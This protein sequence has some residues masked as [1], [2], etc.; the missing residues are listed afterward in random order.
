MVTLHAASTDAL[1]PSFRHD[2]RSL[3]DRA[4]DG[5]FSDDD[6]DHALGGVHVWVSGAGGVISHGSLVERALVC[7]GQSVRAGYVEALATAAEHRRQGHGST[8][9][10]QIGELIRARYALGA[11]STGTHAFYQS[12]GWE[13]WRGPTFVDSRRGRQRTPDDDG[14]VMILRTP[15]SPRLDPDGE[16][17][18]DWRAG[19]VW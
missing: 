6:W 3:L 2:L 12:L 18:C 15:G 10:K 8:V 7:S 17:T 1:S 13:R 19:D 14:G 5:D 16:I 4:F 9:M 11:L